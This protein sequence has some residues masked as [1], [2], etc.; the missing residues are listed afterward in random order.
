MDE[1]AVLDLFKGADVV[2]SFLGMV[3]PPNW[4][5]CPGVESM[6]KAMKTIVEEGGSPPKV[7]VHVSIGD[8]RL[9]RP[10][11]SFQLYHG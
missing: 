11:E 10:D 1:A 2:L 4:V 3:N 9:E 8:R 7:G 5:V 6:V